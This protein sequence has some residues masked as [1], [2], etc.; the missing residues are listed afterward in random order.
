LGFI[1]TTIPKSFALPREFLP[2]KNAKNAK[3]IVYVFAI[4][5]FFCG[6]HLWLR[7]QPRWVIRVIR[8]EKLRG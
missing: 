3:A 8:G 2:R 6:N 5:A 1:R 7:R 4:S